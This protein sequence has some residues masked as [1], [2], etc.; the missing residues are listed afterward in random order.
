[1]GK[2]VEYHDP[3]GNILSLICLIPSSE[4]TEWITLRQSSLFGIAAQHIQ[5]DMYVIIHIVYIIQYICIDY[6][7][8]QTHYYIYIYIY[9]HVSICRQAFI[10]TLHDLICAQDRQPEFEVTPPVLTSEDRGAPARTGCFFAR[11]SGKRLP[12]ENHH[13]K[14]VN[15]L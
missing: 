9:I 2:I 10:D 7:Q 13:L 1:M 5:I 12:M 3:F 6:I 15:P 8:L 11:P 4:K 14:W